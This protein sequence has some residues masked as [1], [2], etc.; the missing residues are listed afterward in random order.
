MENS[1][2]QSKT[3]GLKELQQPHGGCGHPN[4][5]PV[6]CRKDCKRKHEAFWEEEGR[7]WK[8]AQ[9]GSKRGRGDRLVFFMVVTKYR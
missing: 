2:S 3:V 5:V 4:L 9:N 8:L 6:S 1:R 7:L